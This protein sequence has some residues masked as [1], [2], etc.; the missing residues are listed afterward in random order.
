M[1]NWLGELADLRNQE[2]DVCIVTIVNVRG[3]APRETGARMLVTR[4][5]I[6][7]SIGGGQLEYQCAQLAAASG[8]AGGLRTFP[9]GSSFGQCCGGVVDVK[10]DVLSYGDSAWMD[11]A[12]DHYGCREDFVLVSGPAGGHAVAVDTRVR[13]FGIEEG[14]LEVV[15][16]EST[17]LAS[18]SDATFWDA[19]NGI[20]YQKISDTAFEVALFGAGHVGSA[21][22]A[23]L[24][25]LDCRVRWIDSRRGAFPDSLP[26]NVTVIESASPPREVDAMPS[27]SCYV[28]MTHSHALDFDICDRILRR[29]NFTYCGL[30]GSLSKRRRFERLMRRQGLPEDCLANLTCPIGATG[31]S[32]KRPAEIAI[33]VAAELLQIQDKQAETYASEP[34][35]GLAPNVHVI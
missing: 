20:F 30:I 27:G 33:A 34:A 17:R 35:Q 11:C 13:N 32:G 15:E 25:M 23:A 29:G 12:M 4:R 1:N 21:L 2:Q 16:A 6:F 26:N 3:S 24:G 8:P 9:L 18:S 19:G 22:V 7:G 5:G 14:L 10:F 28:V 31:I